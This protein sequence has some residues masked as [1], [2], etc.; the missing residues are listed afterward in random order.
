MLTFEWMCDTTFVYVSNMSPYY[1]EGNVPGS[2]KL[3]IN[4]IQPCHQRSFRLVWETIMSDFCIPG[5][6]AD[7]VR[8][9]AY[10][11]ATTVNSVRDPKL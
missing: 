5:P 9:I 4:K 3:C 1:M 10:V 2:G 6:E 11:L 7:N 8:V